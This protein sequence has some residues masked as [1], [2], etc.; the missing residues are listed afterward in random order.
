LGVHA[1]G[2]TAVLHRQFDPAAALAAVADDEIT[3][4]H[5]APT[6]LQALL[7]ALRQ[8]GEHKRAALSGVRTVVYSAAPITS[9]TLQLALAAMPAAGF[10]NLYG[11]TEVIT[12]GLPRELHLTSSD[13]RDAHRLTSV[14]H[15]FPDTEVRIVDDAGDDVPSGRTGEIVVRSAAMFRGYWN[16]SAATADTIRN[17][18]CHTGDVGRIDD[19]GLL[20]LVDR[21]KDVIISGGENIYSVEVEDAVASH[22]DVVE[23]AVVG[24]PDDRWGEAVC[25]VVVARDGA[26]VTVDA[27]RGHVE[28]RIARYK[29]PKRL[30]LVDEI[31][32]LPTGKIDKKALRSTYSG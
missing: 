3:V 30:V 27:L 6:M 10:L 20:Y 22:P 12:S 29:A 4:L 24:V 15:P 9:S 26:D 13:E 18:W 25:A 7:Q 16:D 14:G 11:Q 28:G 17:G 19:E 8:A 21:K 2:G 23:C 1:R 32:K 31:P 5:L